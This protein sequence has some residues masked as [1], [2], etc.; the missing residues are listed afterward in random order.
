MVIKITCIKENFSCKKGHIMIEIYIIIKSIFNVWIEIRLLI[1]NDGDI[2]DQ[3]RPNFLR[4]LLSFSDR[5]WTFTDQIFR[6]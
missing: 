3:Q 5:I 1:F 6:C 4:S 2:N